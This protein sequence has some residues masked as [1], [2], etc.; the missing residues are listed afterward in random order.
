MTR[1]RPCAG[2]LAAFAVSLVTPRA[3]AYRPF[4]GTDADVASYR[5]IELEIGPL[6]YLRD[7]EGHTLLAP[8]FVFNYGIVP[9]VELVLQAAHAIALGDTH[10]TPRFRLNDPELA[11]KALLLPG[12]LQG[13]GRGPS[14]AGELSV[15]LPGT[16]EHGAGAELA[17]IISEQWPALTLHGN[18][19]LALTRSHD[20]APFVGLIAEGPSRWKVRPVS[21][22]YAARGLT[23]R[24]FR[25]GTTLSGLVGA[26]WSSS[27]N[28]S[29]DLA[30]RTALQD[31]REHVFELRAGFTWSFEP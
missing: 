21:E 15:L 5:E 4:D 27:E 16:T 24:V 28:L 10:G 6:G 8:A 9:R 25:R 3:Y 31:G 30:A 29:F 2:L 26:I 23:S 12:S 7:P 13:D 1:A 22:L 19:A 17:G 20:F 11:A 18:F 14:L